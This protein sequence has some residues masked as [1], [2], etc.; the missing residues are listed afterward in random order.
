LRFPEFFSGTL[1]T[2]A[3]LAISKINNHLHQIAMSIY[4]KPLGGD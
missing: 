3:D 1:F 2:K 4:G